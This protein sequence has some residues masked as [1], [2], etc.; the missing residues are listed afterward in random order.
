MDLNETGHQGVKLIHLAADRP[1][2]ALMNLV[3]LEGWTFFDNLSK[4]Q[5]LKKDS[6][7]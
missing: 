4:C 2:R 1:R 6:A 3:S 7:P 5:F